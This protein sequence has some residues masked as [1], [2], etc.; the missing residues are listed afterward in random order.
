MYHRHYR[1]ILQTFLFDLETRECAHQQSIVA[2]QR[3]SANFPRD[4]VRNRRGA[5]RFTETLSLYLFEL[6][7]YRLS[8]RGG[9]HISVTIHSTRRFFLHTPGVKR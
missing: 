9:F 1:T 4:G 8:S 5:V 3:L 7:N 2:I 6:E